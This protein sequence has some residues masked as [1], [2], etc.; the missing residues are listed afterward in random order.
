MLSDTF[1]KDP[2]SVVKSGDKLSVEVLELDIARK[3]ISLSAKKR[4]PTPKKVAPKPVAV[5]P[6]N[7]FAK[8]LNR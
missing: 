2:H 5:D 4:A 3:R 6:H 8:L 1:V 7:P